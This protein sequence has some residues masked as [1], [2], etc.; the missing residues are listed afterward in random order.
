MKTRATT[1]STID[2]HDIKVSKI[3]EHQKAEAERGRFDEVKL[4]SIL[5]YFY[6]R[7][8]PQCVGEPDKGNAVRKKGDLKLA[9]K[10]ARIVILFE[11]NYSYSPGSNFRI[12][13]VESCR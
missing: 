2:C 4:S 1:S 7:S 11:V 5:Q 6:F 10:G 8:K 13:P 12:V 9:S 3:E